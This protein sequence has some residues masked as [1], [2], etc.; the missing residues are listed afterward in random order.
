MMYKRLKSYIDILEKITCETHG[1]CKRYAEIFVTHV[2]YNSKDVEYGTL[3]VCKGK[4][5]KPEY[6]DEAICK[7][8]VCYI[9]EKKLTNRIP[10]IIVKDI[11]S[12]LSIVSGHQYDHIWN[13]DLDSIG[14][15][16]T[17]GKSTTALL[18]KSILDAY[19]R[20]VGF[21]ETGLIS[22]IYNYDGY[23]KE[24]SKLTTPETL[25][26]HKLLADS[27]ENGCDSLVM[28]VSS[29]GLKYKRVEDLKYRIGV[30]LNIG[31]DHISETEHESFDD[32]FQSKLEIFKHCN[33]A[34]INIDIED[35]FLF[36]I[37]EEA[38]KNQCKVITFGRKQ[39]AFCRG[40][41]VKESLNSL[42][43][44][45]MYGMVISTLKVNIGG[46]CNLT[47][48]LAAVSVC[49]EL[50][51]SLD[52]VK[53][54]LGNI[55]IP[56]RMEVF[57]IPGKDTKVVVD[58]AHNEMSYKA[59]FD[60]IKKS[61]P[62]HKKIFMFC[63]APDRAQNRRKEAGEIAAK[64]ADKV[65]ITKLEDGKE[66]F[67]DICKDIMQHMGRCTL[68]NAVEVMEDRN[69]A[70]EHCL[71]MA[72]DGWIVVMTGCEEDSRVVSEYLNTHFSPT[73]F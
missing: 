47:N 45:L 68:S 22:G 6:L 13:R 16:G 51:V 25:E 18:I 59:L 42:E 58:Y 63:C 49:M 44:E 24:K 10:G 67:E 4:G 20:R 3:F 40:T 62:K 30:F 72:E 71:K 14:I 56:G 61:Y 37:L 50:G 7:G 38:L 33:L 26:L 23:K 12:A 64:E 35:E 48:V 69:S 46:S 55:R 60:T 19:H 32:Y 65:V 34:C 54:G 15:T 41:L 21:G 31:N 2:S 43:I 1:I 66:A 52:D 5:F 39:G 11:R 28:E 8:A 36:R 73:V 29:Q 27:V 17:K 57:D 9:A 53:E 70:I